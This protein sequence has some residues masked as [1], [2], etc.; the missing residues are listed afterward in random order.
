MTHLY[1][2]QVL[3]SSQDL[4]EEAAGLSVLQAAL[5]YNVIE[6]LATRGILHYQKQLF[7]RFNNFIELN[8]IRM[9]DDF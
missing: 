6:E 7:G 1:L 9:S 4:V 5:L 3:D 2:M 8:N